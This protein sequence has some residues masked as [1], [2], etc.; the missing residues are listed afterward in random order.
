MNAERHHLAGQVL[1]V[2]IGEHD[3]GRGAGAAAATALPPPAAPPAPPRGR[4]PLGGRRRGIAIDAMP[5]APARFAAAQ[6]SSAVLACDL[7]LSDTLIGGN[8]FT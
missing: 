5:I 4:A 8:A 7:T 3:D 1:D 6:R 2:A